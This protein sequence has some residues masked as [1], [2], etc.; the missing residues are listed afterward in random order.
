MQ[1][2]IPQRC[3]CG[4]TKEHFAPREPVC[5]SCFR[6]LPKE[7]REGLSAAPG[8]R[9][10]S[11]LATEAQRLAAERAREQERRAYR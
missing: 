6:R 10:F 5:P 2:L 11:A 4:V 8:P 7:L 3:P 9:V 1:Q